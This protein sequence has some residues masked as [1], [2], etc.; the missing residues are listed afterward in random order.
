[1]Q[2]QLQLDVPLLMV[3]QIAIGGGNLEII[4]RRW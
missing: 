1:M 3:L 2:S 4:G